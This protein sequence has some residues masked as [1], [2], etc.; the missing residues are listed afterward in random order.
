METRKHEP[1][2][3]QVVQRSRIAPFGRASKCAPESPVSVLFRLYSTEKQPQQVER[4]QGI[5]QASSSI[6]RPPAVP[7]TYKLEE[8]SVRITNIPDSVSQRDL[9]ELLLDRCGR[10]FYRCNLIYDRETRLSRGF[11]YVSS[12]N[13]EKAR[14]LARIVRTIVIDGFMLSAEIVTN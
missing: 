10:I 14:E 3:D 1:N 5:Y 11:A 6:Y 13:I 4:E 7:L 8:V 12:E 9:L 2:M